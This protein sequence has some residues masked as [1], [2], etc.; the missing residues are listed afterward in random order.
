MTEQESKHKLLE[1]LATLDKRLAD[2]GSRPVEI[3]IVG[4]FAMILHDLRETGFT[5]DIVSMTREF[6]PVVRQMIAEIGKELVPC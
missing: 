1:A 2:A 5:Q 6:E 3:R 4:G